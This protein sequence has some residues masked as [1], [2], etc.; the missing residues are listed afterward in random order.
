MP[1]LP[2]ACEG[3]QKILST[4]VSFFWSPSENYLGLKC[5]PFWKLPHGHFLH[6]ASPGPQRRGCPRLPC[7]SEFRVATT[8]SSGSGIRHQS[9]TPG[10]TMGQLSEPQQLTPLPSPAPRLR[11][12]ALAGRWSTEGRAHTAV[13]AAA[14]TWAVLGHRGSVVLPTHRHRHTALLF[15]CWGHESTAPRA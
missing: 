8:E 6:G 13:S 7:M 11:A 14:G 9:S 3:F 2:W 1:F 15:S 10:L 4:L 5:L 12:M